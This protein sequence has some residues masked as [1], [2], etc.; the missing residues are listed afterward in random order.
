MRVGSPSYQRRETGVSHTNRGHSG[1]GGGEGGGRPCAVEGVRE[2]E[3]GVEVGGKGESVGVAD[4]EVR[5]KG[6]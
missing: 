1:G 3:E 6:S 5:R 4:A 2:E